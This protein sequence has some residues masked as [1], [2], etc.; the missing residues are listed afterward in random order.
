MNR[1]DFLKGA[2]PAFLLLANG[3]LLQAQ[4]HLG[5]VCNRKRRLRFAIASDIHYGQEKT[6]FDRFLSTAIHKINGAHAEEAFDFC[7]LNGDIVH[8]DPAHYP[9]AKA[10][11]EQ[12]NMKWYVTPGN[13][14]RVTA[15]QWEAI[16]NSPVNYDFVVNGTVFLAAATSD[17]KGGY[18]CP[19]LAW[20][21]QQ[22]QQ[23]R[24]SE[25]VFI[26]IHINPA[27]L[28]KFGID[29][30]DFISLLKRYR[31]VRAVFNGHDH[32]EDGIKKRDGIP[33]IFDAHVGGDWGTDYKGFRVVE[34]LDD[35][36]LLT[37]IM[38]P[39]VKMN[40]AVL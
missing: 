6:E 26:I 23:Y 16:W 34:L 30:P 17:E 8:N 9:A 4:E 38:N 25:N 31:N 22:L 35:N 7:V 20:M 39:D 29:C 28:T 36:S 27:K 11:I 32:D 15:A 21:E 37:Y 5:P 13:H 3:R 2:V 33:F 1:K 10:L 40:S 18:I 14:D 24:A 12:L 19:D